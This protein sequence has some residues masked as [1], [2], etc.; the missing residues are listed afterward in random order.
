MSGAPVT[1]GALMAWFKGPGAVVFLGA[2]RIFLS[3][4]GRHAAAS[5]TVLLVVYLADGYTLLVHDTW[6]FR[7]SLLRDITVI[8][9]VCKCILHAAC[10]L[11]PVRQM[12]ERKKGA[13]DPSA[14]F[15]TVV[16][17]D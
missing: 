2:W 12:T 7:Q 5:T 14:S 13:A 4:M 15:M 17:F 3:L 10:C 16:S 11:L 8:W 1:V 6:A 9:T